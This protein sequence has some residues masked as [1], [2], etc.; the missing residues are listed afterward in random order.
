MANENVPERKCQ[1]DD[2]KVG[3]CRCSYRLAFI[4]LRSEILRTMHSFFFSLLKYNTKQ[5]A[6]KKLRNNIENNGV[7]TPFLFRYNTFYFTF[8]Q[9][10]TK[11]TCSSWFSH[12]LN[13]FSDILFTWTFAVFFCCFFAIIVPNAKLINHVLFNFFSTRKSFNAAK[14]RRKRQ[15]RQ[16]KWNYVVNNNWNIWHQTIIIIIDRL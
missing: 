8:Q 15:A 13:S 11:K 4:L 6:K 5:Q 9:Q 10:H 16:R 3:C 2:E 7:S 1:E 12:L 14:K